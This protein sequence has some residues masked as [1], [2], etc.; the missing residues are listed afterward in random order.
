MIRRHSGSSDDAFSTPARRRRIVAEVAKRAVKKYTIK[1]RE[2]VVISRGRSYAALL[3]ECSF[4]CFRARHQLRKLR[5]EKLLSGVQNIQ[6]LVRSFLARR[7]VEVVRYR[8]RMQMALLVQ[9]AWRA[10]LARRTA[11][12]LRAQHLYELMAASSIRIQR[13]CRG[14]ME[15][16]KKNLHIRSAIRIQNRI[17]V[18]LAIQ[19]LKDLQAL[20]AAKLIVIL[21]LLRWWNRRRKV[22]SMAARVIQKYLRLRK[23]FVASRTI[24][25]FLRCC[26]AK[27]K[28]YLLKEILR[29]N[30]LRDVIEI[31][32]MVPSSLLKYLAVSGPAETVKWFLRNSVINYTA[33]TGFIFGA[34]LLQVLEVSESSYVQSR[35][36]IIVNDKDIIYNDDGSDIVNRKADILNIETNNGNERILVVEK[37]ADGPECGELVNCILPHHWDSPISASI[38]LTH[39]NIQKNIHENVQYDRADTREKFPKKKQIIYSPEKP[40]SAL[41][42]LGAKISVNLTDK[43]IQLEIVIPDDKVLVPMTFASSRNSL[44]LMSTVLNVKPTEYD[45]SKAITKII[46]ILSV[47]EIHDES[48]SLFSLQRECTR[49]TD[50]MTV[51]SQSVTVS[52]Y[53]FKDLLLK[54]L[55]S[56]FDIY[57]NQL[58]SP[59]FVPSSCSPSVCQSPRRLSNRFLSRRGS[60]SSCSSV[61]SSS[62]RDSNSISKNMYSLRVMLENIDKYALPDKEEII[63]TPLPLPLPLPLI[64]TTTKYAAPVVV[65]QIPPVPVFTP[66]PALTLLIT[67]VPPVKKIKIPRKP[68]PL[69]MKLRCPSAPFRREIVILTPIPDDWVLIPPIDYNRAAM[70]LQVRLYN[71]FQCN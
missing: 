71:F 53:N 50:I 49:T 2:N 22:R 5:Q 24:Q 45:R 40:I 42:Q 11:R 26:I 68:R 21:H 15:R 55:T 48:H 12:D 32:S 1:A 63:V 61:L 64:D 8:F 66:V 62:S 34:V 47:D 19:K 23:L 60:A 39:K 57:S 52:P 65:R 4:R 9:C 70:R 6:C 51:P 58:M 29:L 36:D 20:K 28:R 43:T 67:L 18:C 16:K 25:C 44:E 33:E 41:S 56:E 3:I 7:R 38:P 35:E 13:Y 31:S 30:R 54:V 14:S 27:M 17:R 10:T 37:W 59:Y 46:F 69:P